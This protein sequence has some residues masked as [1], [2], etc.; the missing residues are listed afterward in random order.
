MEV[1]V[2]LKP[3]SN[4]VDSEDGGVN[5]TFPL[6]SNFDI[7]FVVPMPTFPVLLIRA[8]SESLTWKLRAPEL[9]VGFPTIVHFIAAVEDKSNVAELPAFPDTLNIGEVPE[10]STFVAG[11]VVPMPTFPAVV[12]LT[13]SVK[14]VPLYLPKTIPPLESAEAPEYIKN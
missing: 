13:V 12:N 7:G 11:F 6:T 1:F 5:D 2:I 3:V 10:I 4:V 9:P 8:T 14:V